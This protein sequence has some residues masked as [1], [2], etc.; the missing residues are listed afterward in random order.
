VANGRAA[1]A[2]IDEEQPDLLLLDVRMPGL[3]RIEVTAVCAPTAQ[4]SSC[5]SSWTPGSL[6]STTKSPDS[7]RERPISWPSRSRPPSLLARI[8]A[9]LRTKAAID[10]L[11]STQAVLVALANAVEAK[12]PTEHHC[13]RLAGLAT[14]VARDAGLDV[15]A[16]EAVSYGAALHDIGKIGV[17]EAI[18]QKPGQLTE[19]E[20]V[21]M[22]RHPEIGA[23]IVEPL[24]LSIV[25]APIVRAHHERWDGTGYPVGVAGT[26]IPIGARFDSVPV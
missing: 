14:E 4:P 6:P 21:D 9:A 12:D 17:P 22:R 18:L 3:D 5:R 1:L 8:R 16:I 24:R 10:R 15:E 23:R 7:T 26:D 19:L 25:V 20:W 13:D 2:K 11:K